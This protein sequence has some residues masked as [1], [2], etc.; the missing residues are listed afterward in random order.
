MCVYLEYESKI[1]FPHTFI[2]TLYL[3]AC[4]AFIYWMSSVITLQRISILARFYVNGK[5]SYALAGRRG[6][7]VT[8]LCDT[9]R[10]DVIFCISFKLK[11][12][13][14]EWTEWKIRRKIRIENVLFSFYHLYCYST[15]IGIVI[16]VNSHARPTI[17]QMITAPKIYTLNNAANTESSLSFVRFAVLCVCV[18]EHIHF[19][20]MANGEVTV[21]WFRRFTCVHVYSVLVHSAVSWQA[22]RRFSISTSIIINGCYG[23]LFSIL[24]LASCCPV[25]M[26]CARMCIVVYPVF[27]SRVARMVIWPLLWQRC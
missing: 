25:Y 4:L 16:F 14:F 7:N 27:E 23:S 20:C 19:I 5:R 10:R 8:M 3:F 24:T 12:W 13:K 15:A 17:K 18:Y 2:F 21:K 26:C 1:Q 6:A 9:T 22:Y 11:L